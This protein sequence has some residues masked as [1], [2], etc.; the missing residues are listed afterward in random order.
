[1]IERP[2]GKAVFVHY[3][4]IRADG[5]K[6]LCE[7]QE[8]EFDLYESGKGLQAMNVIHKD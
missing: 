1:M 4:A 7:G 3:S 2:D 6:T 5:Y 8:V